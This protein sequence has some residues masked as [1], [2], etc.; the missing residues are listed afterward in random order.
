VEL[1]ICLGEC[2]AILGSSYNG[3]LFETLPDLFFS[4]TTHELTVTG[5]IIH[6]INA[7]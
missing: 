7:P 2:D 5:D 1:I 6:L 3:R 4:E